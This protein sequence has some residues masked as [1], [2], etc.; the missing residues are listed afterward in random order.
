[1]RSSRWS[2]IVI[3]LTCARAAAADGLDGER[4]A[5]SVG[6][7]GT[8]AVEHPSVAEHKDWGIGLF[9][10]VA[11]D[12]IVV[13]D[14]DDVT[15]RVL[16]T[17]VTAELVGSFG[18]FGKLELGFGLPLHLV[19]D[20]QGF[21]G[22]GALLAPTD[23]VG[24]LRLVPKLALIQDLRPRRRL[25]LSIGLPITLP[26]GDPEAA[27]GAGGLTAMPALMFGY[28]RRRG[29]GFGLTLGYKLR[30]EHPANLP[31]GDAVVLQPWIAYAATA[32]LTL[33]AE[34]LAEKMT[35]AAVEGADFPIELV[36]GLD[37]RIGSVDLFAGGGIGLSDGIG[38]P[39]FRL[40]G[41]IRY[42]H[43]R[44][45]GKKGGPR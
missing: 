1:M 6:V 35:D 3:V 28:H 16:E 40:I 34:L 32:N 10:H 18:L 31:Y 45:A 37:Y 11:S 26:T 23:G 36:P 19:Y 12:P 25:L 43:F 44:N 14:G 22:G 8:F 2:A 9:F 29:I 27:R 7:E 42:R 39:A 4:F 15:R 5:P 30:E 17:A 13:R 21:A 20:G 24:D 41:G 33:R 38:A